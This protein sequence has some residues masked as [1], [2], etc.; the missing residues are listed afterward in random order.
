MYVPTYLHTYLVHTCRCTYLCR[1]G[2]TRF[3]FH[4]PVQISYVH[5]YLTLS[6][7][8]CGPRYVTGRAASLLAQ[9]SHQ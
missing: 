1:N 2:R 6:R 4:V 3:H 7:P 8:I 5:P 9:R